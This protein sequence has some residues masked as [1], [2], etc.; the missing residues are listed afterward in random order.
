[1][2]ASELARERI[3]ATVDSIP[4]GRVATYGQVAL[5][6]GLQGRAR[7]VGRALRGLGPRSRIPWWRVLGAGGIVRV[8]G[9]AR[10][11]QSRKLAR[12]GVAVSSSGRVDLAR[13]H[14]RAQG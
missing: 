7:L 1:M 12:E 5:E 8:S 14:W 2:N 4:R 13:H 11:E 3:L 9:A 10:A 6:A